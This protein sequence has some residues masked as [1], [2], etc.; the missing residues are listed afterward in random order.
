[1]RHMEEFTETHKDD[2]RTEEELY[3][4]LPPTPSSTNDKLWTPMF[5]TISIMG[6]FMFMCSQGLNSGTSVYINKVGGTALF[7]GYLAAVFSGSAGVARRACGTMLDTHGRRK[8]LVSGAALFLIGII[9]PLFAH[10]ETMM[11]VW[12]FL[13]G[14]GFGLGGTAASTTVADV[15]PS[16]R[17]GEGIGYFALG[18]AFSTA[19]G[20]ALGITLVMM[21]PPET[22]FV[23][24]T[25]ACGLALAGALFVR[26][27]R[28]PLNLPE[29]SAFRMRW[30]KAGGEKDPNA[31]YKEARSKEKSSLIS[32]IYEPS[33]LRNAIPYLVLSPVYGFGIFFVS[34][35]GTT[36]DIANPGLFFTCAAITMIVL[37]MKSGSFMDKVPG[38]YVLGAAIVTGLIAFGMLLAAG[39]LTAGTQVGTILFYGAG[40]VY[41]ISAGVG[42]PICQTI[43]VRNAPPERWGAANALF[44]LSQDIG[45]GA[46]AVM[47]G[48]I[49]DMFGF[50]VSLVGSMALMVLSLG[51]AWIC[52]PENEKRWKR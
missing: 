41:G 17:L 5:I 26:Y 30:L 38:I 48:A 11:V 19:I 3:S 25:I 12:R 51:V 46:A 13:Q 49:N 15:L 7:S 37:R 50:H 9:G 52:Y 35:Y 43:C 18:Q 44:F 32:R 40:I 34:L 22:M 31:I 47:W 28:N 36:L 42:M 21:E 14:A 16:A 24:F 29:T 20:P 23:G 2:D 10:D 27:E 1:M 33:A 39:T 6:L 45:I 8:F 4:E